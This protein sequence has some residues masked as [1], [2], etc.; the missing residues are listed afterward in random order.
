M[1]RDLARLPGVPG[2]RGHAAPRHGRPLRSST[3]CHHPALEPSG[4]RLTARNEV[5]QGDMVTGRV[6]R[7][8]RGVMSYHLDAGPMKPQFYSMSADEIRT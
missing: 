4:A 2:T 3:Y 5:V 6:A 1:Q 8:V 7:R